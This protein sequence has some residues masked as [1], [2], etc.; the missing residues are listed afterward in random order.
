V[1]RAFTWVVAEKFT[2]PLVGPF[3]LKKMLFPE[4][5]TSPA[6]VEPVP[7]VWVLFKCLVAISVTTP[8]AL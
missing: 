3:N 8:A 4:I 2:V 7:T 1:I 5:T 6:Y